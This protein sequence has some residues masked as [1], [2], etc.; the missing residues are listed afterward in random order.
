M[1]P[2]REIAISI[3]FCSLLFCFLA[4]SPALAVRGDW[5]GDAESAL[6][7]ARDAKRPVLAVAMDH[8]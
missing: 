5:H 1:R 6:A 3:V 2:T 7:A 8:G 4:V